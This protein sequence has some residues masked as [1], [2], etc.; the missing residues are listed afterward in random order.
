MSSKGKF[1]ARL[2][3]AEQLFMLGNNV[4]RKGLL[5]ALS[6]PNPQTANVIERHTL[7][8]I[9]LSSFLQGAQNGVG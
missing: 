3:F 4:T 2:P 5:H 1:T 8:I 9:K 6:Q 7:L